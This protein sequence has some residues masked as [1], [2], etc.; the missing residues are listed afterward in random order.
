[1][2]SGSS[3]KDGGP[4]K[5]ERQPEPEIRF[6]ACGIV[7]LN[8]DAVLK[9]LLA[10]QVASSSNLNE[11]AMLT[12]LNELERKRQSLTTCTEDHLTQLKMTT[13]R[14]KVK[15]DN[16]HSLQHLSQHQYMK[17]DY[18]VVTYELKQY[19]GVVIN[20]EDDD[21]HSKLHYTLPHSC[22]DDGSG[23]GGGS[24]GEDYHNHPPEMCD[25]ETRKETSLISRIKNLNEAKNLLTRSSH[26]N[27]IQQQAEE[28]TLTCHVER[29]QEQLDRMKIKS[30]KLNSLRKRKILC[31]EQTVRKHKYS[32]KTDSKID[33]ETAS[34]TVES[35]VSSKDD[36][37]G[38]I[39]ESSES[40]EEK[41][42]VSEENAEYECSKDVVS[43]S[44]CPF[45]LL[46]YS[47]MVGLNMSINDRHDIVVNINM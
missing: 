19:P 43:F 2:Y 44:D 5:G 18:V 38:L 7:P 27:W 42:S 35:P 47:V 10:N 33:Q 31:Q 1:M 45:G 39:L 8:E 15:M 12:F 17:G 11:R 4:T 28:M 24:G 46:I 37:Q 29:L 14:M 13:L 26:E 20:L 25:H 3:E 16:I 9:K 41:A 22:A 6:K 30:E 23:D 32:T 36:D 40:E 21:G 34:D